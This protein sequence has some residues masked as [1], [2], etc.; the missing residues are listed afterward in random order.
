M[1]STKICENCG[2]LRSIPF[3]QNKCDDCKKGL[4]KIAGIAYSLRIPKGQTVSSTIEVIR[5]SLVKK[6]HEID[7]VTDG[8]SF[9]A[10]CAVESHDAMRRLKNFGD[11][12]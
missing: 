3:G 10:L 12:L 8:I 2:H 1:Y 7:S 5:K 6:K 11:Y 4:R 9:D